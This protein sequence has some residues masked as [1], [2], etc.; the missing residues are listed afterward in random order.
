MPFFREK[1][2]FVSFLWREFFLLRIKS[3]VSSQN[4]MRIT[5][6]KIL[7]KGLW[8][9]F[10][11]TSFICPNGSPHWLHSR[12]LTFEGGTRAFTDPKPSI[13]LAPTWKASNPEVL[14]FASFRYP[15]I[16]RPVARARVSSANRSGFLL[17]LI[18]HLAF[19]NRLE[20]TF[21]P[22]NCRSSSTYERSSP[23]GN[24]THCPCCF[25]LTWA[26]SFL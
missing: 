15:L 18:A 7:L 11:I 21:S 8:R 6:Q 12:H 23:R 4:R 13:D 10:R 24:W 26:V 25:K 5:R 3:F 14:L 1:D 20:N 9:C 22:W 16:N 2:R 17:F 19:E